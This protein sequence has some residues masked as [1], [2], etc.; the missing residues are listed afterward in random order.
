MSIFQI[1]TSSFLAQADNATF[2]PFDKI[3]IKILYLSR[4]SCKHQRCNEKLYAQL[5][6]SCM[7]NAPCSQSHA[8]LVNTWNKPCI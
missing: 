5:R 2:F 4:T 3:M 8:A 7:G 1:M 6:T